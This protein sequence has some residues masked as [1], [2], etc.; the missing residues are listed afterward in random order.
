[1]LNLDVYHTSF[2]PHIPFSSDNHR[3]KRYE[4]FVKS[5]NKGFLEERIMYYII[6]PLANCL[7]LLF[8]LASKEIF[9]VSFEIARGFPEIS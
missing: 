4:K 5:S 7:K 6:Q 3:R 1:M 8:R 9:F 2:A